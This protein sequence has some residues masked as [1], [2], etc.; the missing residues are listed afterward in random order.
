MLE[1]GVDAYA[2]ME[3][4]IDASLLWQRER[5]GERV[6]GMLGLVRAFARECAEREGSASAT[7]DARERWV[8]HY[9]SLARETPTADARIG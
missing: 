7:A 9:V 1:G 5:D 2:A 4:L 8:S 3:A 6:F